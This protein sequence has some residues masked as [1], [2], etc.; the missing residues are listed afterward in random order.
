[1]LVIMKLRLL[2]II[3][4]LIFFQSNLYADELSE[5]KQECSEI[6]FKLG[7]EKHGSCVLKLLTKVKK[8][9]IKPTNFKKPFYHRHKSIGNYFD[10]C[11]D[12]NSNERQNFVNQMECWNDMIKKSGD[13]KLG[14]GWQS[15]N[16]S[17]A[18][19]LQSLVSF[20]RIAQKQVSLGNADPNLTSA[21]VKKYALSISSDA[22]AL[23]AQRA[24]S[25]FNMM[26][27]GLSIMNNGIPRH[28]YNVNNS[29]SINNITGFLTGSSISG[30]NRICYYN[31]GVSKS[32][33]TIASTQ[34][35]PLTN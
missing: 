8:Q 13:K 30:M 19:L 34:L 12:N 35:C 17:Y 10:E 33:S 32:V 1:M 29:N 6:G 25:S 28:D 26:M 21:D 15:S 9:P 23:D 5:L 7:T 11:K 27:L 2:T 3:F 4:S 16:D 31:Q 22:N 18:K 14:L 20:S 24:N